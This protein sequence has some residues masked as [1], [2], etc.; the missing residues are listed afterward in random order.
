MRLLLGLF[1]PLVLQALLFIGVFVA[2]QGAGSFMGLFA[3]PVAPTAVLALGFAG[4]LGA[5]SQRPIG[6]VMLTSLVIA[7][8]PPMLLLLLRALES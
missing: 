5:R 7:V 6:K 3:L 4:W 8:V 2:A 1:L